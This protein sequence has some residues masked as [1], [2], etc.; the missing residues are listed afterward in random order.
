MSLFAPQKM[1]LN[2]S[3]N[4]ASKSRRLKDSSLANTLDGGTVIDAA[5]YHDQNWTFIC[6]SKVIWDVIDS[7]KFYN[8]LFCQR[9]IFWRLGT[10]PFLQMYLNSLK[11]CQPVNFWGL[12][13]NFGVLHQISS[14][15]VIHVCQVLSSLCLPNWLD[16]IHTMDQMWLF[17]TYNFIHENWKE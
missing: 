4:W 17:H 6:H 3:K 10:N 13:L 9:F 8:D 1:S 15:F 14:K 5:C 2:E 12:K 16:L 7:P 11:V